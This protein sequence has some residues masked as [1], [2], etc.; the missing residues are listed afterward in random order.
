LSEESYSEKTAP[1]AKT[2]RVKE[3]LDLRLW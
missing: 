3:D 2:A 1:Y